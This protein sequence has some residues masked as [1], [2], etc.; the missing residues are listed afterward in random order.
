MPASLPLP[1]RPA[2]R[3]PSLWPREHGAYVELLAPLLASLLFL[4]P[5]IAAAAYAVAACAAF[6]AHEPFL[7]LLGRRGARTKQ[8]LGTRAQVHL[9][10]CSGLALAG[11][12]VGFASSS[13]MA[14]M[15]LIF[16]LTLSAAACGLVLCNRERGLA[17]LMIVAAT[18]ASFSL[19]GLVAS[20]LPW[21]SA[22]LLTLGW[23]ALHTVGTLTARAFVYRK[24]E[25]KSMLNLANGAALLA[26]VVAALL[27]ATGAI[28]WIWCLS[29]LPFALLPAALAT[30]AFRPRSPKQIGWALVA[31]NAAAL[32]LFGLGLKNLV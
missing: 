21:T 23:V 32:L 14:H 2:R 24:R 13:S 20:G 30:G 15:A 4:A 8:S 6:L 27:H 29:P 7:V 9:M 10:V 11:V 22:G 17:G 5:S 28:P 19:P 26:I 16:P 18:L 12:A 25:G 3:A 31:V 1:A